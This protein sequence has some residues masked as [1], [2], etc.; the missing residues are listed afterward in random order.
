LA[1][2]RTAKTGDQKVVASA[3]REAVICPEGDVVEN[4]SPGKPD[5]SAGQCFGAAV[6][7]GLGRAGLRSLIGDRDSGQPQAGV[8]KNWW[9]PI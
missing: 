3:R 5:K 2:G 9:P 7:R 1:F 6:E 8:W 4:R